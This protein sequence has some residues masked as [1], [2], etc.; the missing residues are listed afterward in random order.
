MKS[1]GKTKPKEP[2]P[3]KEAKAAE[4]LPPPERC[5]TPQV[6]TYDTINEAVHEYLL[7]SGLFKTVDAFQVRPLLR[8]I[9]ARAAL[10][11]V[12]N[13]QLHH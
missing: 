12:H 5:A 6:T 3:E 13:R 9:V 8:L 11:K 10:R 4:T 1:K 7:K 2:R